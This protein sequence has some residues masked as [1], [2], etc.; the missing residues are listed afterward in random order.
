MKKKYIS[1]KCRIIKVESQD[2]I[3]TSP[4]LINEDSD[5]NEEAL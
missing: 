5:P 3:A 2:I 1:P 4:Y